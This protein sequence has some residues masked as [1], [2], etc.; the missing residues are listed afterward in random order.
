MSLWPPRIAQASAVAC[1]G[2]VF[3][4]RLSRNDVPR[5]AA[6]GHEPPFSTHLP[7]LL[8]VQEESAQIR[9]DPE[10]SVIEQVD[11]VR[12]IIAERCCL[13][14]DGDL[15]APSAESLQQVT[16]LAVKKLDQLRRIM[17]RRELWTIS[18][19][20]WFG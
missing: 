2:L 10:R 20:H 4:Q 18:P 19:S 13:D 5:E 3:R 16:V 11:R 12:I 15:T 17:W 14:G 1:Y 7:A 8:P 6:L 9:H